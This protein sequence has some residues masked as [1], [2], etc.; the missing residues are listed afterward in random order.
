MTPVRRRS[1]KRALLWSAVAGLLFATYVSSAPLVGAL[2]MTYCGAA[3]GAFLVVYAPWFKYLESDLPGARFMDWFYARTEL[4][5]TEKL[6]GNDVELA[7]WS[8]GGPV[9]R[10]EPAEPKRD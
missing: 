2:V 6:R 7:P 10:D 9:E 1:R 3:H 5:A 4:W 8:P